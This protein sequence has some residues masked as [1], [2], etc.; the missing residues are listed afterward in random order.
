MLELKRHKT[1]LESLYKIRYYKN[2]VAYKKDNYYIFPSINSVQSLINSKQIYKFRE[3][4]ILVI[5]KKV[6]QALLNA[7]CNK[8]LLATID[9]DSMLKKLNKP[10]FIDRN[11]VYLCSNIVNQEFFEKIDKYK[12]RV[13]KKVIYKTVPSLKL[14][15]KLIQHLKLKNIYGVLF[16]SKLSVEIFL[17][18]AYKHSSLNLIKNVHF[19][20]ISE[21]VA[22]VLRLKKFNFIHVALKPNQA[23]IIKKI[24]QTRVR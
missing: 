22:S 14:S 19:Y 23:A 15:R 20:C 24:E 16:F 1:F 10:K 13:Q 8:I 4:N 11:F 21:R 17:S 12:I 6:K 5:G 3:A 2:K 9:S 7:G 18:L